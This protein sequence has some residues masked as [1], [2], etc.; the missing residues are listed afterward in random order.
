MNGMLSMN[1]L[2]L[3]AVL[4]FASPAHAIIGFDWVRVGNQSNKCELQTQG[5]FGEVT[6]VYRISRLEITNAQYT[7][8]LNSVALSDTNGLYNT[9]MAS[10]L[11]GITK[12]GCGGAYYCT[13]SGRENKPVNWVSF[14]DSL[15]FV[16]WI[17]NGQ[18]NGRQDNST[19]EDGAYTI[20]PAGTSSNTIT[21]NPGAKFF[22]T[23]EDEWYKAA[24]Y[25]KG[26]TNSGYWKYP[27]RSDS[28]P[29]CDFPGP[30]PNT[31]NCT[32]VGDLNDV[33]AY[34]GSAS[35]SGTFDQA[36][37]LWEWNEAQVSGFDRGVRGGSYAGSLNNFAAATRLSI[38]PW[39][40][41][42]HVGFRIAGTEPPFSVPVPSLT[43]FGLATLCVLLGLAGF[44]KL[45]G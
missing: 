22:L 35:P 26:G 13:I 8:F 42:P 11:G 32:F 34:T 3:L 25:K 38:N 17:E 12:V 41:D 5:C 24:Y 2:L 4:L 15:R 10:G 33:G 23:S 18:P 9:N 44:R 14:Y 29:T 28:I 37:N 36:S 40:E 30:N 21:R 27:A 43:P 31:A 16:N 7:K 45:K 20:T 19:T 6:Y 39:V 1:R